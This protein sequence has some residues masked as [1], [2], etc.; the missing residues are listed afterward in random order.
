MEAWTQ[1]SSEDHGQIPRIHSDSNVYTVYFFNTNHIPF[2][3]ALVNYGAVVMLMQ[4]QQI[5]ENSSPS[6]G[7]TNI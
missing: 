7:S 6:L 4:V 5:I 1:V 2:M 3:S